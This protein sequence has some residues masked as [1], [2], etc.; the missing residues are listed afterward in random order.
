MVRLLPFSTGTSFFIRTACRYSWF[1]RVTASCIFRNIFSSHSF[2]ATYHLIKQ[3][4][5]GVCQKSST[6]PCNRAVIRCFL[7]SK[8]LHKVNI[9]FT[10][11]FNLSARIN[12]LGIS[13]GQDLEHGL[14]VHCRIS[15]FGRVRL[16]Q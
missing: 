12:I 14:W 5:A 2:Q 4:F 13:I 7:T 3:G 9:T 1:S 6:E 10:S 16:I 15:A 8:Q 11:G